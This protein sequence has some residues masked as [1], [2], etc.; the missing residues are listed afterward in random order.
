M[1]GEEI[2]T[3]VGILNKKGSCISI[4]QPLAIIGKADKIADKKGITFHS[5]K[6]KTKQE[7]RL[8]A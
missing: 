2:F 8:P 5:D 7:H 4:S 6:I 3:Q 1:F